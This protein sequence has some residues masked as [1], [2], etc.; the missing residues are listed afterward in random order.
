MS[1]YRAGDFVS[2][3]TQLDKIL[4][5]A[6]DPRYYGWD[7]G[8]PA[9]A[10]TAWVFLAMAHHQLGHADEARQWLDK[11]TQLIEE[12]E[13]RSDQKTLPRTGC[14]NWLRFRLVYPEAE[15]LLSSQKRP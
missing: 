4:H 11:A 8:D 6:G 3:I 13:R 14:G 2:A 5:L 12:M 9:L 1:D 7:N 15:K 10:G